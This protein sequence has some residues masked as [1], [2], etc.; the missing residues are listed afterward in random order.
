ME[1]ERQRCGVYHEEGDQDLGDFAFVRNMMLFEC[2]AGGMETAVA[3]TFRITTL[4]S[5]LCVLFAL[6]V[7]A[8]A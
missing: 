7:V 2:V 8:V 1:W 4:N 6:M 3:L 5:L